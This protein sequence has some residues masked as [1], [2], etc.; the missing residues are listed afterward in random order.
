MPALQLEGTVEPA[1]QK[2]PD[3][4]M[5]HCS[6]LSRA[7]GLPIRIA[8]ELLDGLSSGRREL[9][10]DVRHVEHRGTS[11]GTLLFC[12]SPSFTCLRFGLVSGAQGHSNHPRG[13]VTGTSRERDGWGYRIKNF[14][15]DIDWSFAY[16]A[17]P[18]APVI[19]F[20]GATLA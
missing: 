2:A 3:G 10:L 14:H 5:V 19:D 6:L 18:S 9:T 12:G 20:L 15:D 17:A 7:E 1:K 8:W 4:Q 11:V 13:G 16:W